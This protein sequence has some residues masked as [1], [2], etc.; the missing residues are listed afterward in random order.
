MKILSDRALHTSFYR[1]LDTPI[2]TNTIRGYF[3]ESL[4]EAALAPD[5]RCNDIWDSWDLSHTAST[6]RM[7]VKQSAVRQVWDAPASAR[8]RTATPRFDI[9]EREQMWKDG[10]LTAALGRAEIYLFGFHP[11]ADWK[12]ADQ[13]RAEQW[14]FYV[15]G[16]SE[17]PDAKSISLAELK[18]R[19]EAVQA[20]DLR[21]AVNELVAG[22]VG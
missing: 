3:V 17:L 21:H 16:G 1:I 6:L 13:R 5:W 18:R 10:E 7:E 8:A 14:E 15:I 11:V 20:D 2:M 4:V 9:R 12:V 22:L 19:T